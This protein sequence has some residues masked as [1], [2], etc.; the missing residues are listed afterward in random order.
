MKA[1]KKKFKNK[2]KG[3]GFESVIQIKSNKLTEYST[4][5]LK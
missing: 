5:I 1:K 2:N 4:K 3:K